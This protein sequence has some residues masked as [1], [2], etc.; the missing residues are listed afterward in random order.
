MIDYSDAFQILR[1]SRRREAALSL[2]L[3]ADLAWSG[4]FILEECF[5]DG[6]FAHPLL[7]AP[8]AWQDQAVAV[9]MSGEILNGRG[10]HSQA[11]FGVQDRRTP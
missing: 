1:E 9:T 8:G 2:D 7:A 4:Q 11:T 3:G 6:F 5:G 10:V